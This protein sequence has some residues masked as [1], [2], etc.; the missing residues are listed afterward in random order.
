MTA[1]AIWLNEEIEGNRTL[2]VAADSLVSSSTGAKLTNSAS[3]VFPLHVRCRIPDSQGFFS[4]LAE[5]SVYG[6][7]FAGST[8]FGQNSYLSLAPLLGNL[9]SHEPPNLSLADVAGY[10]HN[11]LS[12]VYEESS[13]RGS[14]GVFEVALFGYC[15]ASKR[16][17]VHHFYPTPAT[18]SAPQSKMQWTPHQCMNVGDVI[19]LGQNK[20]QF[21]SALEISRQGSPVPG[22]PLS[23]APKHVIQDFIE[24]NSHAGIGGDLQVWRANEFGLHPFMLCKPVKKGEPLAK[25]TYLGIDLEDSMLTL[26][27]ARV[28]ML[29]IA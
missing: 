17:E 4:Q 10:V 27:R 15:T 12:G 28:G 5:T 25:F 24:Q 11:F 23:R 6:Y 29:G 20:A 21:E 2:E 3:K 26:G 13:C 7:A 19:Y 14:S 16:L 9:I 22:R 18:A 8:L 1:I